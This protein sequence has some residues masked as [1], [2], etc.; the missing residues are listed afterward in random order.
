MSNKHDAEIIHLTDMEYDCALL[1]A[2]IDSVKQDPSILSSPGGSI[3]SS[4]LTFD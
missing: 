2:Q 4:L 1:R 3:I